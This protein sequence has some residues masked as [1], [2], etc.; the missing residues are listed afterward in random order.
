MAAPATYGCS[1]ARGRIGAAAAGLHTP[2]PQPGQ[3]WILAASV[4]YAAACSNTG[5]LTHWRRPGIKPTSS[6]ILCWALN[7]LCHSGNALI[8]F[9]SSLEVYKFRNHSSIHLTNR[10]FREIPQV[11]YIYTSKRQS[12]G[13]DQKWSDST[14]SAIC[15]FPSASVSL[16]T[17]TST[18]SHGLCL[19]SQ[20][21]RVISRCHWKEIHTV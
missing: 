20:N 5:S 3:Y 2:Q 9:F 10:N 19:F 18:A 21:L 11:V 15:L 6:W 14:P 16:Q 13:E 7:P 17:S 4:T 8:F 1:Q 12:E